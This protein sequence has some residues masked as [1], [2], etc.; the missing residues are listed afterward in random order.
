MFTVYEINRRLSRSAKQECSVIVPPAIAN[1]GLY[2]T[3]FGLVCGTQ[4]PALN[5]LQCFVDMGRLQTLTCFGTTIVYRYG[6]L[7]KCD[8]RKAFLIFASL[9]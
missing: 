4:L 3:S 5:A 2:R 6:C 7:G 1:R 8:R 9:L